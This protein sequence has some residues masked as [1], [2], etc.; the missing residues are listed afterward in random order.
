MATRS[1]KRKPISEVFYHLEREPNYDLMVT[2]D[3]TPV[4]NVYAA[5]QHLLLTAPLLETWPGPG[6]G[7]PRFICSDVGLF[8]AP[9]QPAFSPDVLI[10]LGV[11]PPQ[12]GLKRKENHSYYL[13][14]YKKPPEAIVEVVSNRKGGELT[15]KR[16]GYAK[17]GVPYYIVWD[18]DLHL[19]K[20]MLQC[21]LLT[22][23][24]YAPCEPWFPE[25][26]LGVTIWEGAFGEMHDTF[27]RWSNGDGKLIPTGAELAEREKQRA[28][29]EKRRAE[30]LAE[31]LRSL[32]I[33]P[34]TV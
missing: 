11:S 14:K 20:R 26:E 10:S 1:I 17:I 24:K 32:G 7:C 25:L 3:D 21:F 4:D 5:W 12:S 18:R 16:Q 6:E 28:D 34:N 23:G 13:W 33:D 8:Y 27:L 30:K 19:R 2:E 22:N 31:K 29:Q 15:T 9:D